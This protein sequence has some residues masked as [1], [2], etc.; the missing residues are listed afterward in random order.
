[1]GT[2]QLQ[3]F[4]D[5]TRSEI[6]LMLILSTYSQPVQLLLISELDFFPPSL[7]ALSACPLLWFKWR[8]LRHA[9]GIRESISLFP[10]EKSVDLLPV[11][12][13]YFLFLITPPPPQKSY[14]NLLVFC[15]NYLITIS[16]KL[17]QSNYICPYLNQFVMKFCQYC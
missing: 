1:M 2:K 6:N 14:Y 16:L 12:N 11:F 10:I 17:I 8:K 4:V 13:F 15:Q 3:H 7:M 9:Y 5:E